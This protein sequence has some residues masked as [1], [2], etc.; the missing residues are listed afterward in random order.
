MT[1]TRPRLQPLSRSSETSKNSHQSPFSTI[2]DAS[3]DATKSAPFFSLANATLVGCYS[4]PPTPM[5]FRNSFNTLSIVIDDKEDHIKDL[6]ILSSSPTSTATLHVATPP[7]HVKNKHQTCKTLHS[8]PNPSTPL[9]K[10]PSSNAGTRFSHS[11]MEKQLSPMGTT[12]S[13]VFN[14]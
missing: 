4:S 5:V 9:T 2:S 7:Q 1:A 3:F 11:S 14:P 8:K 6:T 12:N 10:Q 13:M